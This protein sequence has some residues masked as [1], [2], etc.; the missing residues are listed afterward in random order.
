M[1]TLPLHC[2]LNRAHWA[3][4]P[5]FDT[6]PAQPRSIHAL[7]HP[8][9]D[10]DL[11]TSPPTS[12][13]L[14]DDDLALDHDAAYTTTTAYSAHATTRYSTADNEDAVMRTLSPEPVAAPA[15][16][17]YR[18]GDDACMRALS[19]VRPLLILSLSHPSAHP[20]RERERSPPTRRPLT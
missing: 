3:H 12:S 10:R 13:R 11:P 1:L 16:D 2:A 18:D 9:L 20:P 8:Q 7:A 6:H 17:R 4:S 15:P 19:E 14:D 5:S